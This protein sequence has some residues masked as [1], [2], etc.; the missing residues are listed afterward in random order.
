[1]ITETVF[2]L[3]RGDPKTL[4]GRVVKTQSYLREVGWLH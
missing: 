2:R 3:C 1:L 4:T